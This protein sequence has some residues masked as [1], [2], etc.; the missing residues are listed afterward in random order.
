[1]K[2][3]YKY[4]LEPMVCN[5]FM[6]PKEFRPIFVGNQYGSITM[7]AIVDPESPVDEQ[8]FYVVGTGQEV[9]KNSFYVG[10]AQFEGRVNKIQLV[11]HVFQKLGER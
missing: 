10:T 3:I 2:T 1:M 5:K 9:P 4:N 8:E 11:W 7:W 6:A